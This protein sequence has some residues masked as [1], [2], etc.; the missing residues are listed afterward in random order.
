M[1]TSELT[2]DSVVCDFCQEEEKKIVGA[3]GKC[4]FCDKDICREHNRGVGNFFS[5]DNWNIGDE[6]S[7]L[8]PDC[9]KLLD[10]HKYNKKPDNWVSDKAN[11][12]E[13]FLDIYNQK[14]E[15]SN[16][17][18]REEMRDMLLDIF[19]EIEKAQKDKIEIEKKK[20]EYEKE[21]KELEE[22]KRTLEQ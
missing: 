7:G 9:Y 16:N 19:S 3:V 10:R 21:I 6:K 8:C 12:R 20:A 2:K 17:K 13:A 11:F 5:S 22:R 18:I 15:T 14:T 1:R 4:V